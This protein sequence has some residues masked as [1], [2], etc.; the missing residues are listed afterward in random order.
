MPRGRV[1]MHKYKYIP[2]L[3]EIVAGVCFSELKF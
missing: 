2:L 3:Q 1:E